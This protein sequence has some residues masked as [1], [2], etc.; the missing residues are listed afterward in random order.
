MKAKYSRSDLHLLGLINMYIKN[1]EKA[2]REGKPPTDVQAALEKVRTQLQQMETR[3]FISGVLVKR[4]SVL[5]PQGL[6]RLFDDTAEPKAPFD[7]AADARAL[8]NRWMAGDIDPHLLRGIKTVKGRTE[9]G[10]KR[11][12]HL[13]DSKYPFKK[14]CYVVGHNGLTN[15]Q[16]W[17]SRVCAVRDGAHAELEAGIAGK[18]DFGAYSVVVSSG[19]YADRDEGEVS[20]P[21]F[22]H[23]HQPLTPPI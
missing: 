13:L 22:S 17:P 12:T 23:H 5:E 15:G 18:K 19:G 16:W 21:P 10:L 7:I 4:S 6:P 1:W 11:T 8:Y 2:Y 3:H 20:Q 9:S 14:D